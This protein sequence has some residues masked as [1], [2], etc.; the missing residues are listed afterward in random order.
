M[1]CTELDRAL[2]AQV[3]KREAWKEK[4]IRE[5][6]ERK[7]EEIR[8]GFGATDMSKAEL[9]KII[10][11]DRRMY[12]RTEELN[13]KLYI[14][15]KGWREICGLE[16]W[17]GLRALYAEC[18]A[19]DK[20]QGLQ[21]CRN[22]RSLFLSENC[23][24]KIE[25][26]ENCTE[27]WSLNLSNNFIERI[28]GL[29]NL[30]K[31]NTLTIAK[32]KL[33]ME[34]VDDLAELAG[35]SI[36][37]LDVQDNKIWDPDVLPEVFAQMKELRV[38]YLK[39]NPCSKKIPNYRKSITVYCEDLTYL[40]DRPVFPD[41][42]RAADAFNKGGLEEERA[43]RRRIKEEANQKHD[44][45]MKAFQDMI[46]RVRAE[47]RERDAMRL[48][49]KFTDETDPVESQEQRMKK[50]VDRWKEEN[51]EDLKDDM[52]ERAERCLA[53]ERAQEGQKTEASPKEEL[54]EADQGNNDNKDNNNNKDKEEGEEDA[55]EGKAKE[56]KPTVYEDIWDD[57]PMRSSTATA[58]SVPPAASTS[59][60]MS[61]APPP[62]RAAAAASAES[63]TT[64]ATPTR[65]PAVNGA[66]TNTAPQDAPSNTELDEM[67]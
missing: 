3:L 55:T 1:S 48:E 47:K 32:N 2:H 6:K 36:S 20:I 34:G 29:G 62:R 8:L 25:G 22:L 27:L 12:Y 17:T 38:L 49:D 61:F 57:V 9:K 28:E 24:K 33:G 60:P 40:D 45:N 41:D 15:Y 26:L 59:A 31:L 42:R 43:E 51:A 44:A 5:E 11:S 7:D 58:A 56:E 52:R 46:D 16:G 10:D 65:T 63:T 67:D 4:Q 53:A 14:H 30:K 64:A 35:S 13:D 39:G 37:S 23:I 66:T 54:K 19:F 18:N 21:M 50:Q